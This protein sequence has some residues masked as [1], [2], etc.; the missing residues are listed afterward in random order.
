MF[1]LCCTDLVTFFFLF[2]VPGP[3]TTSSS[4]IMILLCSYL[5]TVFVVIIVQCVYS[6]RP[7]VF[8]KLIQKC[9]CSRQKPRHET[10]IDDETREPLLVDCY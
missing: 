1:L 6:Y 7:S 3:T 8:A 2:S 4:V 10:F 5:L 9:Y